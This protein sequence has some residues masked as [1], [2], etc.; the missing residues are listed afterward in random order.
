MGRAGPPAPGLRLLRLLLLVWGPLVLGDCGGHGLVPA[1]PELA[2]LPPWPPAAALPS[3]ALLRDDLPEDPPGLLPDLDPDCRALLVLF[4]RSSARLTDCLGRGARPVRVCQTCYPLFREV[5]GSMENISRAAGPGNASESH[6]CARSL[7]MS[8]RMQIVVILSEFFNTTWQEANCANCLMN[9]SEGLS[10]STIH[11][12]D[13]F[14]ITMTCFE[15]NLQ[16]GES[17]LQLR[18]YTDVCKNCRES[19]KSLSALYAE[20]QK[21]NDHENKAEHGTH[22]CIDV[23]DAMNVTRKL[24]SRTFNCSVPCSDTVPVIAVS[25]FVL[26]LPVVFYLSSFLHSEQKKRKLILPKRIKSSTSFANIQ[27]N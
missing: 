16:G 11:F 6:N 21:R 19:Y 22:L 26:F 5:V 3:L 2:R 23:E 12:L 27:D 8:D 4:A 25:V 20:M 14:N 15:Q 13:L 9:N 10:N 1:G 7:L 18:N 24:W 17:S